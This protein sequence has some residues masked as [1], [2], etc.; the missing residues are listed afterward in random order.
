MIVRCDTPAE[1]RAWCAAEREAGRSLGFVATMG[2]LHA[3]HLE[4][5]RTALAQNDRVVVSVFV[6]PLQF[7]NPADLERYP[8]DA[9]ADARLLD[10]VGCQMMFTGTLEE[11]FPGELEGGALPKERLLDP[12]PAALGLEG[13]FRPGHFAGVAT[14]VDRLFDVVGPERAYFGRKDY[15]QCLVVRDLARRRGNPEV[16]LC[17][18]VREDSGLALSSRNALLDATQR[19]AAPAIHGALRATRA[20]WQTGERDADILAAVLTRGLAGHGFVVEYAEV[21]DPECWTAERPAGHL[22]QAVALVAVQAGAVRLIDNLPL[23]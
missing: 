9:D 10:G 6:N 14:I 1:A 11:F 5:V 19:A 2:A 7:N 21:R 16:V 8:R 22:E 3:G 20:L 12:G 23:S 13:E 4:L 17:P 18:T 15:Q